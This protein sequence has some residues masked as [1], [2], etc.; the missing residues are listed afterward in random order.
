M[1]MHSFWG[2]RIGQLGGFATFELKQ[3]KGNRL[4]PKKPKGMTRATMISSMVHFWPVSLNNYARLT[5]LWWFEEG[6]RSL[7]E[8]IVGFSRST[9]AANELFPHPDRRYHARRRVP[10]NGKKIY[11]ALKASQRRNTKKELCATPMRFELM[12]PKATAEL[13]S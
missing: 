11:R 12:R 10:K 9:H 8:N 5:L 3:L 4:A 6:R 2:K 7:A 1:K 13:V